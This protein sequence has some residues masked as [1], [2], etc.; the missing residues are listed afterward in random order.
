MAYL[1]ISPMLVALRE[2]PAEFDLRGEKLRHIPSRHSFGFTAGGRAI[3]TRTRCDCAAL[4]I[5]ER[6]SSALRVALDDWRVG[7]WEPMVARRA[8]EKRVA[9]I[10]RAFARHFQPGLHRLFDRIAAFWHR[11]EPDTAPST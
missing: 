6:Q 2:R 5:T 7:Y 11:V 1:D 9:R 8:E 4:T 3:V 10:N